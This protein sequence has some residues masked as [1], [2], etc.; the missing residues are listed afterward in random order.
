VRRLLAAATATTT[1]LVLGIGLSASAAPAVPV[2]P[3]IPGL[4]GVVTTSPNVTHVGTV[5]T[6]GVGVSLRL[7]R[8]GN[9]M[10]AF[11]SGAAGLSIYDATNPK[12]PLLLG[13]L[14]IYNWENEAIAVSADGKT[15]FLTEFTAGLYLDVIDVSNPTVPTLVASI[16]GGSHTVE[17]ADAPC[18]YLFGSEGQTFDV[19]DRA[20]PV[21]LPREQSWGE[22]TGAGGGH[23]LHKDA[24]GIWISDTDP[25]VVFRLDPDPL[26]L[27]VLSS[28][29]VTK[30]TQYQHNNIRPRAD[31]YVPRKASEGLGGPLR[32][33]ELLLGEGETNFEAQCNG[34]NGA[35]STWSMA[36]FDRGVKMKQLETLRPVT[37]KALTEDPAVNG[38]GCSGHWFSQKNGRDGSILVTAAWYEHGTR[39]LSVNPRNGK[40]TQIGYFQP[41]R[42]STSASYWFP[43]T[44]VIWSVDYHSGIDIMT[45]DQSSAKRPTPKAIE[46]SWLS[47]LEVDPFSEAIRQL[48][49][50]GAS[51]TPKDHARLHALAG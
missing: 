17:C 19:R 9:E 15:A 24:A 30:N 14:P 27:K 39:I 11:V 3:V 12:A 25:L 49:R 45:F 36:G 31:K 37:N 50:A 10:R 6:E 33:G 46:A 34:Q 42:G 41:N 26:H 48:C 23:N 43:G 7:V 29:R 18:G 32:D 28:G 5:P 13:H 22:L 35:F 40:I 2:S 51:V 21:E 16:P 44:D 1:A 20:N 8:M 47:R 38:L 4:P